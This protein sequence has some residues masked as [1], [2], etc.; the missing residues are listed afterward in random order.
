[1]CDLG[2]YRTLGVADIPPS[3]RPARAGLCPC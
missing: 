3:T 2:T 1:M